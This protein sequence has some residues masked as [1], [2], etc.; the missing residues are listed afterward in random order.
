MKIKIKTIMAGPDGAF[1][2]GDTPDLAK[3][4]AQA[5]VD[6][7]F[8]EAIEM[9]EPAEDEIPEQEQENTGQDLEDMSLEELRG[10][11]KAAGI[12]GHKMN[13]A[14]LIKVLSATNE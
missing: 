5:L 7:G 8:A 6:G 14:T 10:L 12:D 13:K 11:A 1:Q 2:P 3:G 4:V 9:P